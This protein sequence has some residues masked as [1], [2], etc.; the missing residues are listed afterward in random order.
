MT[1][2][3]IGYVAGFIDGEG[4]LSINRSGSVSIAIINTS[5]AALEF[6]RETL[7]VGT[8]KARKQRVNKNQF[9]YTVY[10]DECVEVLEK[11]KDLLIDKKAQAELILEFRSINRSLRIPGVRGQFKNPN[12][13]AYRHSLSEMKKK[14]SHE[15]V[16]S[17]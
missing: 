15:A 17:C 3:A 11:I 6:V 9:I 8:V 12:R 1:D 2:A 7:G 14:E 5:L 4:C 16:Y 13:D 10:G